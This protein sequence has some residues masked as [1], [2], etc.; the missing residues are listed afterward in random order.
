[1]VFQNPISRKAAKDAKFL[2]IFWF[3]LRL[4]M[5]IALAQSA[6][7]SRN[8]LTATRAAKDAKFKKL[9]GFLCVLA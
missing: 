6:S 5:K 4:C 3:S 2:K 7:L 8:T 9:F 1:M